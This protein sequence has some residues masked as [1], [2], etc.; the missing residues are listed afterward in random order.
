MIS[1]LLEAADVCKGHH[2][3][4]VFP[5]FAGSFLGIICLSFSNQFVWV[6]MFPFL[7]LQRFIK[8][9]ILVFEL[10]CSFCLD[11]WVDVHDAVEFVAYG[12]FGYSSGQTD[13]L[14]DTDRKFWV[15]LVETPCIVRNS[16]S[17]VSSLM[18]ASVEATSIGAE[19]VRVPCP[20]TALWSSWGGS[21]LC[22][23]LQVV[24]SQA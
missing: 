5:F 2:Q 17:N 1:E 9:S 21:F 14:K 12:C 24:V 22:P 23:L 15:D 4:G 8:A 7:R 20:G 3:F 6:F 11:L 18:I 10:P 19:A 16:P 13:L